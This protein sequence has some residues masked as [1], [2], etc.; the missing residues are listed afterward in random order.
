MVQKCMGGGWHK[1]PGCAEA[2][3]AHVPMVATPETASEQ[4]AAVIQCAGV[5]ER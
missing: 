4:V 1:G 5:W 3:D 2:A